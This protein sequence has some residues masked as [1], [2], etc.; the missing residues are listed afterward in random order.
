MALFRTGWASYFFSGAL[1]LIL[2]WA[3]SGCRFGNSKSEAPATSDV[4]Y[5][6]TQ[7]V[8][9]QVCA[10]LSGKKEPDCAKFYDSDAISMMPL[11]LS[12]VV[13]NPVGL[14]H[15]LTSDTFSLFNPLFEGSSKPAMPIDVDVTTGVLS[16]EGETEPQVV[17]R[18]Q[19]CTVVTQLVEEGLI[20]RNSPETVSDIPTL[21]RMDLVATYLFYYSEGC[22]DTLGQMARC[23]E[24]S[25]ECGGNSA[26]D[27]LLWQQRVTELIG[28]YFSSGAVKPEDFKDVRTLA[29]AAAFE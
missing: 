18:D 7:A 15:F 8:E 28:H 13:G 14:F 27:N 5:Y 6:R 4:T 29:F 16:F 12:R 11:S 9:L 1:A 22:Q 26:D 25:T 2:S 10:L 24:K 19:S 20:D 21:G 17:W 3:L 23:Y